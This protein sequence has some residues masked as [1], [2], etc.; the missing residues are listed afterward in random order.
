MLAAKVAGEL[1][2]DGAIVTTDAGGNSHTDTM[3]TVRACEQAGIR[4]VALVAE[5]G[6]LTDHVP[7]ADAIVSVGN[8]EELVPE[9]RPEHV[10]GGDV[11]LD[12]RPATDVRAGPGAQLPRR[13]LPDGRHGSA[14]GRRVKARPL[15]EPVLRRARRRGGGR[16][17]AG[18][19]RGRGRARE[20]AR[21]AR[22][23]DRRHARLRRR[24]LRRAGGSRAGRAAALA[25]R[26]A[27]RRSRL[28]PVVRI[29]PVRLRV[30]AARARSGQARHPRGLR[31]GSREPGGRGCGGRRLHRSDELERRRDARGASADRGA[32]A[33]ARGGRGAR[34]AGGRGLPAAR[35]APQRA[36]GRRP[37]PRGRSS[38]CSAKLA[39]ATRT[40]VAA[41][42]DHVAPPP[43][44]A[45]MAEAKL[46][47]V[48]EAGCV[49]QGNPDGLADDPRRRVAA[50]SDRRRG[51][52]S[53]RAATSRCTAGST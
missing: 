38:C 22:R 11:L 50:L 13:D 5:M 18:A 40:E 33:P 2:A 28:R 43:P 7:E 46:A 48:T 32:R 35:A 31:H 44:V 1:G 45:T 26:R 6:G 52:R 9:W 25:R 15:P 30:R 47:L 49:P 20:G 4:A 12:G 39:G 27:P 34:A 36:G 16:L 8:A 41:S 21:A 24:L 37:V 42:F 53:R 23:A 10:V 3:L 51:S 19:A 17:A 14:G 29:R